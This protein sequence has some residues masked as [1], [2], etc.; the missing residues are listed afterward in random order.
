M[1]SLHLAA[2]QSPNFLPLC[3]RPQESEDNN[4][5]STAQ[6]ARDL[7]GSELDPDNRVYLDLLPVRSFLHTSGGKTSPTK[8]TSRQSPVPQEEQKEPSKEVN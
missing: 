3:Y 5:A 2:V 8:D 6:D 7:A 4:E 1:C